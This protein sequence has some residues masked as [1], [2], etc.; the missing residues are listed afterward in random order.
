MVISN[1]YTNSL[2]EKATLRKDLD[3]WRGKATDKDTI[4]LIDML[5][6]GCQIQV[7]HEQKNDRTV[8]KVNTVM[9]LPQGTNVQAESELNY[10]SFEAGQEIS[11]K[12]PEWIRH[13][14]EKSEE[15]REKTAAEIHHDGK[16]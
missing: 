3:T 13:I 9:P 11:E 14:I 1:F 4:D 7:I 2:H 12:I 6:K 8:A 16:E 10:F 5:G 15:Y